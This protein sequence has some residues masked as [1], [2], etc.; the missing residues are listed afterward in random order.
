MYIAMH[1]DAGAREVCAEAHD[2]LE[3]LRQ[4]LMSVHAFMDDELKTM[5]EKYCARRYEQSILHYD[6][7]EFLRRLLFRD[8]AHR[9]GNQL[10]QILA[11]LQI[12]GAT[13]PPAIEEFRLR[14]NASLLSAHPGFAP[15]QAETLTDSFT[16][17]HVTIAVFDVFDSAV[18]DAQRQHYSNA[19]IQEVQTFGNP[20]QLDHGNSVIDVILALAP[21]VAVLPISSDTRSSA[22][23][24]RFL[25]QRSDVTIVNMSRPLMQASKGAALDPEFKKQMLT[26]VKDKIVVKALGNSGTDLDGNLSEA[27]ARAGLSAAGD[28]SAYDAVLIRELV[29]ALADDKLIL[30]QSWTL[31]GV[32][33]A[34]TATVP[35]LNQ[36]ALR[37]TVGAP[38]DG[39]YSFATGNFEAGSSFAAPQIAAIAALLLQRQPDDLAGVTAEMRRNARLLTIK[40]RS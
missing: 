12:V 36:E 31:D 5:F 10:S 37:R 2:V 4:T 15:L 13:I 30:A 27:R 33:P 14:L 25:N 19:N 9:M 8:E 17:K 38:A 18:L 21:E 29:E 39:V 1:S 32:R 28:L 16:G 6:D 40:K 34:L 23:A 11:L 20:V 26:L 35:G 3:A 22:E 7:E 24:L